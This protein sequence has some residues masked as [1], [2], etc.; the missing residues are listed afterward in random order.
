MA[1]LV[2]KN[3]D[4]STKP[5]SHSMICSPLPHLISAPSLTSPLILLQT[6]W[7]SCCS[8][9]C[10]RVLALALFSARGLSPRPLLSWLLLICEGSSQIPHLLKGLLTPSL[11]VVLPPNHYPL[12][13]PCLLNIYHNLKVS[14]LFICSLVIFLLS[15]IRI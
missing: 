2:D 13:P 1:S 11:K 14:C 9:N 4:S 15:L 10:P 3:P 7:P 8:L 6:H 5:S 12:T